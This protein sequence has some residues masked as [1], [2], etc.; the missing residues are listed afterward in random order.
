M[1]KRKRDMSAE[2]D[3][4]KRKVITLD[5]KPDIIKRFDNGQS[6]ASI[7]RA[8]GLSGSTVRLILSKS[9]EYKE[10]GKVASTSFSIQCTRN[11]SSVLD[12]MENVLITWPENCNQTRIPIATIGTDKKEGIASEG[13]GCVSKEIL[14]KELEQM[15]RNLETVKQRNMELDPNVERSM[16]VR[17]TLENGISCYRKM[18]EEK[19]KASSVQTT[20]DKYFSIK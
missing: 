4:K 16:L 11:R 6:K 3:N 2:S 5:T 14:I 8:L 9:D 12:E 1:P 13:E 17:R 15:F 18:H 20:L 10:Q 7:S 19:K